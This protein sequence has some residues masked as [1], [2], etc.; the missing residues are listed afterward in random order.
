MGTRNIV[1]LLGAPGSGKGTQAVQ[2]A[3]D[4]GIP[5][6]ASGDLLRAHRQRGTELGLLAQSA[7]DH[8]ELVSDELVT[9]MVLQRLAEA[10]AARGALLDGFPRDA[11]QAE[12]LD[13]AL[14]E[15][16]ATLLVLYLDVPVAGLVGRLAGW[17]TCPACQVSYHVDANPPCADDVCDGCGAGLVQRPD[18]RAEVVHHRIA[19]YLRETMP[20]I[21]H[22]TRLG[23]LRRVDGDRPI[24]IIS[25][26]LHQL[27]RVMVPA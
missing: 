10:D 22:Y 2:L 24:G 11:C 23:G 6:V 18:D 21:E 12:T 14:A 27:T 1:L 25:A 26:E 8:G 15:Q 5:H 17:R 4:L 13:R 16:D 19:V 9:A 3:R 20:V 7:M